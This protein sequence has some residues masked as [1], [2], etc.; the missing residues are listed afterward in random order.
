[1][2]GAQTDPKRETNLLMLQHK[3]L[4]F[5]E[6]LLSEVRRQQVTEPGR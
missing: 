2:E 1:M 4:R 5:K 6:L 3:Y